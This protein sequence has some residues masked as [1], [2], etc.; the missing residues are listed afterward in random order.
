M[1]T[2][3]V[4]EGHSVTLHTGITELQRYDKILWSFGPR[5]SNSLLIAQI[6]ERTNKTPSEDD[7]RFRDR[8]QLN[9]ET[10]DL[11]IKDIKIT[12][13]GDYHLKLFSTKKT[14]SK[15]FR[16]ILYGEQLSLNVINIISAATLAFLFL[17]QVIRGQSLKMC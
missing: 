9:S 5:G 4:T 17:V 14:K 8:L 6:P 1:K 16:V 13:S 12:H 11:T 10:G 3:E 2:K 15:R 7:E